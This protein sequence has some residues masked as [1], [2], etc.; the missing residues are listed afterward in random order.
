MEVIR[1][2]LRDLNVPIRLSVQ[3]TLRDPDGLAMSSRNVRLSAAARN[4]AL[5]LPRALAT[6]DP[7]KARAM[8]DG[9]EVE[10]VEVAPFDPPVLAAAVRVGGVRLIDNVPLEGPVS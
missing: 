5:A 1:R 4:Q 3:P 7:V 9:L 8:L 2:M 10:Y 6:R